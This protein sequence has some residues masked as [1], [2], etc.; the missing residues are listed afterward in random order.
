M[1][2]DINAILVSNG[3]NPNEVCGLLCYYENDDG[4]V[5]IFNNNGKQIIQKSMLADSPLGTP[6]STDSFGG[7]LILNPL[8]IPKGFDTKCK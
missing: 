7:N 4:T 3:I 5:D 1:E 2:I 8:P 6:N